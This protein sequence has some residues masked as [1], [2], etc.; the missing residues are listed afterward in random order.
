MIMLPV[1]IGSI[2]DLDS[3]KKNTEMPNKTSILK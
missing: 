1:N 3:Q 2:T